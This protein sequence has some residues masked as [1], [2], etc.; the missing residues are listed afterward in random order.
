[1]TSPR[2]VPG[3]E[4]WITCATWGITVVLGHTPGT[5]LSDTADALSRWHL[6]H[7]YRAKVDSLVTSRALLI[8]TFLQIVSAFMTQYKCSTFR[9]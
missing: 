3:K 8:I 6:G 7:N 1:M 9:V 4:F 2:P 5:H